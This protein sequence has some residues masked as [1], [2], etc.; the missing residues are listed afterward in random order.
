MCP[1][2]KRYSAAAMLFGLVVSVSSA[3]DTAF[4]ARPFPQNRPA[5]GQQSDNFGFAKTG[6][7]LSGYLTGKNS[8]QGT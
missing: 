4:L 8:T 6:S 3:Q 5:M 2:T 1:N 7:G